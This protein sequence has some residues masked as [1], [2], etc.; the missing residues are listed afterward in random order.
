MRPIVQQLGMTIPILEHLQA[1]EA[2]RKLTALE[3]D[4]RYTEVKQ[5]EEKALRIKD[6]ADK[7]ALEL[8]RQIQTYKDEKANELREQINRERL[9]YASKD[10][11]KALAEKIDTAI[12][13][14]SEFVAGAQGGSK[15]YTQIALIIG[16]AATIITLISKFL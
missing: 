3:R 12:K 13:P 16:V 4:R 14:L 7:V 15:V 6:E 8:A 9:E 2:E 10:D 11:L 1:L 5:A